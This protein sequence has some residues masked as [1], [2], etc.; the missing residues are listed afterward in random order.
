VSDVEAAISAATDANDLASRLSPI[1]DATATMNEQDAAEVQALVSV[2]Q[3]SYE[4]WADGGALMSDASSLETTYEGCPLGTLEGYYTEQDWD[5][6][7]WICTGAEWHPAKYRA[8]RRG[9]A[10]F[11]LAAFVEGQGSCVPPADWKEQIIDGDVEGLLGGL[12]GG[13]WGA[14]SGAGA[15]SSYRAWKMAIKVAICRYRE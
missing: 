8:V 6:V 3:S 11:L 7:T 2:A 4:Y 10:T 14:I 12:F 15:I 1:Y 13:I 9:Q 5:G